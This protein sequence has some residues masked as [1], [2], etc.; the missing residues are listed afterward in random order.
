MKVMASQ[1]QHD[2]YI[3]LES[4]AKRLGMEPKVFLSWL[5]DEEKRP[6]LLAIEEGNEDYLAGRVHTWDDVKAELL[7]II[8]EKTAPG[9]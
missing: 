4:R 3:E 2:P 1:P 5:L 9:S 8:K 6:V 7:A